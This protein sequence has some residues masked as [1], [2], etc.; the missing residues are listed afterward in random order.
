M[1]AASA[2]RTVSG[3][4]SDSGIRRG[5]RRRRRGTRS[6]LGAIGPCVATHHLYA[7]SRSRSAA[8][9]NRTAKALVAAS[10]VTRATC[11]RARALGRSDEL[12][13]ITSKLRVGFFERQQFLLVPVREPIVEVRFYIGWEA[14]LLVRRLHGNRH[15]GSI[16]NREPTDHD[17]TATNGRRVIRHH[18]SKIACSKRPSNGQQQG[19]RHS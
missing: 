17:L 4:I 18:A 15:T 5:E 2:D 8:G 6:S 11:L 13:S 3:R 14:E 19:V 9:R 16:W 1:S 7:S 12:G 10:V